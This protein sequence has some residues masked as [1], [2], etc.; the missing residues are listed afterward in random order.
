MD[1][2]SNTVAS[3]STSHTFLTG[4]ILIANLDYSG[5]AGYALRAAIGGAIWMVF[6]LAGDYISLKLTS[7]K[8]TEKGED[9]DL[10]DEEN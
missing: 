4:A 7:K 10:K 3:D 9:Q 1:M 5:L 2:K 8:K 6:K